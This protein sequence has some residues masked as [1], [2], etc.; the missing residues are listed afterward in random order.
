MQ[1]VRRERRPRLGEDEDR[2]AG[3]REQHET[4]DR[5]ERALGAVVTPR[6]AKTHYRS[7][8]HSVA[9]IFCAFLACRTQL[10]NFATAE[11]LA[12]APR[13]T[14]QKLREPGYWPA[15]AVRRL[16]ATPW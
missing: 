13:V 14:I 9:M 8:T 5:A 11:P 16:Q 1:P 4:R 3:D 2:H 15:F 12:G 6:C 10:M 7:G